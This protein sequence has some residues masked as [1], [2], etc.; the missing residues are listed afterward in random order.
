MDYFEDC[1]KAFELS[2]AAVSLLKKKDLPP[3]PRNIELFYLYYADKLPLLRSELDQALASNTSLTQKQLA[4]LYDKYLSKDAEEQVVRDTSEA[5]ESTVKMLLQHIN[6][7]GHHNRDYDAALRKFSSSVD[8]EKSKIGGIP[9]LCDAVKAV[10]AETQQMQT[11]NM[12]LEERL[13]ATNSQISELNETLDRVH[14][15]AMSDALSGL[16]NRR[17]FDKHLDEQLAIAKAE[18]KPLALLMTDIDH[19]K[20]FNDTYGHQV[21][22]QV[23]KLIARTLLDCVRGQDIV[24]RYGGEEF[25]IILPHTTSGGALSVAENIRTTLASRKLTRRASGESLGQVT[26]SLGLA[27]L[28]GSDDAAQFICRADKGLYMAKR[29]GRNRTSSV[30]DREVLKNS[31]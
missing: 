5:V 19:F 10:F 8:A 13:M 14:R 22:D 6:E 16:L 21:G 2:Y 31:A 1:K 26:I 12:L 7:A 25:A 30:E 27:V 23:I 15:E 3:H 24:A 17:A 28:R 29:G 20:T 11:R 18:S 9:E 4:S